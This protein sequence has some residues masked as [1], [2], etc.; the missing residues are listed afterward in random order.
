MNENHERIQEAL[1]AY[2]LGGLDPRETEQVEDHLRLCEQCRDTVREYGAVLEVLPFALRPTP[3]PPSARL[4]LRARLRDQQQ[5]GLRAEPARR[6]WWR[7]R[8][9]P[10]TK[11][12]VA[13]LRIVVVA[14]GVATGGLWQ[15]A[16]TP[17]APDPLQQLRTRSDV[18]TVALVGSTAAPSASGQ[19]LMTPDLRQ[20][21]VAIRGLPILPPDRSYQVWFDR[22]DGTWESGGVFRVSQEGSA[23]VAVRLPASL[24]SYYGCWVTEEPGGGSQAP[25]GQRVLAAVQS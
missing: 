5:E 11:T 13:G 20:A 7:A 16:P 14:L 3:P 15:Q 17:S 23:E 22:P 19:L 25:T 8:L 2:A 9:Q 4:L 24:T 6:P 18:Q 12:L 10:L 1:A 21:G